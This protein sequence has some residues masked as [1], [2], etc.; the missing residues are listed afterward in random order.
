MV[1]ITLIMEIIAAHETKN[2]RKTV[3][4]YKQRSKNIYLGKK[5]PGKEVQIRKYSFLVW[6]CGVGGEC[7][8]K[9]G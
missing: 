7:E 8:E 3:I 2:Q 1:T 4:S 9:Q 5:I 6:W